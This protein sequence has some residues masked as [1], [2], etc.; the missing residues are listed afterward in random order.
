M[1]VDGVGV[2]REKGWPNTAERWEQITAGSH[3]AGWP[4]SGTGRT[5][6]R[7]R[8]D[9]AEN[10]KQEIDIGDYDPR[11]PSSRPGFSE[12]RK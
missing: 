6:R 2:D 11:R 12:Q 7:Y 8:G 10:P 4:K 9:C 3:F 5:R 1:A